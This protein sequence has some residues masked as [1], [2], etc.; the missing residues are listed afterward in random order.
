MRF[1]NLTRGAG[2]GSNCYLLDLPEG[3]VVLDAGMHPE[4]VGHDATP[5]F[6]ELGHGRVRSTILTHAHQDH[7]GCLPLLQ[8]QQHGMPVL[9]TPG[10]ARIAE[11]MLHNSVNVMTRQQEELNLSD[12]PLFGHKTIE[13]AQRFWRYCP[14]ERALDLDGQRS[15]AGRDSTTVTFHDAGHILGSAGVMIRSEGKSFF[16]TGDVNFEDQTIQT[17]AS[18]PEE[19]VDVLL[20]E[21]TRGDAPLPEGFTRLREEERFAKAVAAALEEGASITI[22]VFALGKTQEVMAMLW[23]MQRDRVI[24]PTP[25]YVGGLSSKIT[26]VYDSMSD[27]VPRNLPNLSLM[28]DVTPY[29]AGGR[30]IESLN[31]RKRAIYALSSGMM[32]EHTLSNIFARKV[33]PDASQYL[34]FVGYADPNSPAGQVRRAEQGSSVQIT[35]EG[36]PVKFNCHREIFTFSAH[37]RRDDLL[38]YAIKVRPKTILLVHGDDLAIE[39]FKRELYQALP[40][41]KVIAPP[42]GQAIEL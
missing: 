17:G 9:M 5:M 10:T 34:Y 1:T 39:W 15:A 13:Q 29:V 26:A 4:R 40:G 33:L 30:D 7:V 22:P 32:T 8:I 2:I 11:V 37:A 14:L 6:E 18:F 12:Y 19:P 38:S 24:P 21:T 36:S 23:K 42:P 20:M 41:T 16:Y 35:A 28:R 31:P 27:Q 3:S 25:L